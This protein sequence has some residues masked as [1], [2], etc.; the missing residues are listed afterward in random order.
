MVNMLANGIWLVLFQ[1]NTIW[2]F[3]VSLFAILVILITNLYIMMVST[4]NEANWIEWIAIRA[5]FSIY[6]GWVTAATILNVTYMLKSWGLSNAKIDWLDEEITTIVI[7]WIAWLIYSVASL[8]ERNP[9]FGAVFI[10][11]ITAI[12]NNA[13]EKELT[14]LELNT[15]IITVIHSV[16]MTAWAVHLFTM[17]VY[18][19]EVEGFWDMGLFYKS[20]LSVDLFPEEE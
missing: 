3:I 10:W 19:I 18:G 7:V 14:S 12:R 20:V 13:I 17:Q 15:D 9:M 16:A 2:G 11:V 4:R 6:S 8:V 5:G 1:T